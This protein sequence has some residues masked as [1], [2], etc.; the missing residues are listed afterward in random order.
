MKHMHMYHAPVRAYE[1]QGLGLQSRIRI[2]TTFSRIDFQQC[3]AIEIMISSFCSPIDMSETNTNA[4]NKIL[5]TF[6]ISKRP[7]LW[8]YLFIF[9][10]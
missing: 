8:L 3:R 1:E 4:K 6:L 5:V 7:N 10:N 9:P 2:F